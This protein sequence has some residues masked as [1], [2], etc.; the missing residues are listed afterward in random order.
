MSTHLATSAPPVSSVRPVELGVT[1][2]QGR[3]AR[4]RRELRTEL[5]ELLPH[6]TGRHRSTFIPLTKYAI[7]AD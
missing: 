5:R 6:S 3:R 4:Q 1:G 7:Q 2:L